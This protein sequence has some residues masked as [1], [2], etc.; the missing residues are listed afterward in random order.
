MNKEKDNKKAEPSEYRSLYMKESLIKKIE[1]I[2]E[3]KKI[4]FNSVIISMIEEIL[5][6]E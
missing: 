6:E 4:S 3:E 5:E 1:K 2:A